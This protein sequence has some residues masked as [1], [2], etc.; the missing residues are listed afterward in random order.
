V[1]SAV[2]RAVVPYAP[3]VLGATFPVRY[4]PPDGQ[5]A[6]QVH[7]AGHDPRRNGR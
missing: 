2:R 4:L 5:G 6:T 1:P 7:V 3:E